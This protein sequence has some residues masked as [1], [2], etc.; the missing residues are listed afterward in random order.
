L[1]NDLLKL[2]NNW[3][4]IS[5]RKFEDAG[6]EKDPMGKKLIE[7]GA[8]AYFN[9]ARELQR[10]IQSGDVALNFDLEVLQQD[11]KSP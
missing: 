4:N 9:C 11:T 3:M 2:S 7:H 8:I 10:A 1:R 6:S 5:R